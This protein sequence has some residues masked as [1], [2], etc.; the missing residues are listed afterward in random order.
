M[1][2]RLPMKQALMSMAQ[3]IKGYSVSDVVFFNE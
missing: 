3:L 1:E 2:R